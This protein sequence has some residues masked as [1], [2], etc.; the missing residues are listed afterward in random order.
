MAVKEYAY[1]IKGSKI[2]I[3]ERDTAFTNDPNARDYGPGAVSVEWKSPISSVDLGLQLEYTYAP[4]YNKGS[5]S[6]PYAAMYRSNNGKLEIGVRHHA[7]SSNAGSIETAGLDKT[8]FY[9]DEAHSFNAG[10]RVYVN[11]TS[12][13]DNGGSVLVIDSVDTL[14]IILPVTF[15]GGETVGSSS[16]IISHSG[17]FSNVNGVN[18]TD[19]SWIYLEDAGKWSGLHKTITKD[20]IGGTANGRVLLET[21]YEAANDDWNVMDIETQPWPS[22]Y[23]GVSVMEDEDFDLDLPDYL[24][25]AL[26]YYLKAK[27]LEDVMEI[28]ASE[29][30]M[31]KFKKQVEKSVS[32]K[33]STHRK[34]QGFWGIR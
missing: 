29:Y 11:G 33:I 26:I 13:Y 30:F 10:D 19:G 3:V 15:N 4:K 9:F 34:V 18:I 5:N 32:G 24:C 7:I 23:A 21:V 6:A 25:Q 14:W 2:G 31:N 12:N 28:E 17:K 16:K 22:I 20:A 1:Y 27:V 8:K